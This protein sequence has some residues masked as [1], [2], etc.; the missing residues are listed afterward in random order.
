MPALVHVLDDTDRAALQLAFSRRWRRL[1]WA[2]GSAGWRGE[3]WVHGYVDGLDFSRDTV[4]GVRET[5]PLGTRLLGVTHVASYRGAVEL[6]LSVL[7]EARRQG[8]A[9]AMFDRAAL[10]A[11]NRGVVE[12]FM[13]CL[14]ENRAMRTIAAR[15]GMRVVMEDGEVDAWIELPVATPFSL[16]REFIT[17]QQAI[18][19]QAMPAAQPRALGVRHDKAARDEAIVA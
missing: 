1:I 7:P 6:G 10:P 15:A 8:I 14:A 18:V 4:L 13:H 11:R 2:C 19:D 12:L 9:S 17:R 16:G 5:T 3:D